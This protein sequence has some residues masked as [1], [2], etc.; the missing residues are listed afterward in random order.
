MRPKLL[1]SSE[2]T[3]RRYAH[4]YPTVFAVF[5]AL[6]QGPPAAMFVQDPKGPSAVPAWFVKSEKTDYSVGVHDSIQPYDV[7]ATATLSVRTK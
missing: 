3:A 1:N 7:A 4:A 2:S 5:S 6:E